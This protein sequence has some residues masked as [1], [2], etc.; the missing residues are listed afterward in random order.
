MEVPG[1]EREKGA[2]R[3]SKEIMIENFLNLINDINLYIQQAQGTPNRINSNRS[4]PIYNIIK[5]LKDKEFKH[6]EK[7][8]DTNYM[9][10]ILGKINS[11]F[12]SRNHE[13]WEVVECHI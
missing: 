1:E 9:K 6:P 3:I 12:L 11:Q 4:L 2:E 10:G 7:R 13:A 8:E 5:L